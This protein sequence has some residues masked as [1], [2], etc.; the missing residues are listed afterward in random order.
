M[1]FIVGG[2]LVLTGA[3]IFWGGVT[4]RLASMIG[5][6]FGK[7]VAKPGNSSNGLPDPFTSGG[8]LRI[9]TGGLL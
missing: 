1:P 2:V 4:G 6:L 3:A 5:A 9:A 8:I 7:E